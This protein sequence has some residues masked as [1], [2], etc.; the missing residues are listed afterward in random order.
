MPEYIEREALKVDLSESVVI[1]CRAENVLQLQKDLSK[2]ID[3]I[4]RQ[5]TADVEE[6]KHGKWEKEFIG[7]CTRYVCS[8]CHTF[9]NNNTSYFPNCGAK[10]DKE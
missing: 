8:N 1:S 10:M 5:P 2:I 9:V 7:C 6:V 4:D 3:C